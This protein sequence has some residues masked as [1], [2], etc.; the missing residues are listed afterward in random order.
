MR[1]LCL[2]AALALAACSPSSADA[3][4]A[5]QWRA[6]EMSAI[7]VPFAGGTTGALRYRGGL[8]LEAPSA[9]FGGLSGLEALDHERLLAVSDAGAWFEAQLSLDAEGALVGLES[10]RI[11]LMRDENGEPFENKRTGDAEG[12]A[13]LPDGRFAVSFEQS[14][15]VRL[16]DLNRDGPFGAARPGPRLRRAGNL[17]RN[18]GLEA[19][20]VLSD[21]RLL[22]GAEGNGARARLWAAGTDAD[23]AAPL[24]LRYRPAAGFS[25]TSMDRLPDG[26]IVA[27]ERFYAPAIGARARIL[28]FAAAALEGEADIAPELLAELAPPFPIDNFEGVAAAPMPNG[29]VRLYLLSDDNFRDR[30]RTLLLAFDLPAR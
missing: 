14:Q 16:Y 19:L 4:L 1:R 7:A 11:A 26:D 30:Q 9:A 28:R 13:Q 18:A 17:P 15:S 29:A 5:D 8:A 2:A 27:L 20:A 23:E 25:L 22:A 21:G 24:P 6:L 10:A 12:L 3:P